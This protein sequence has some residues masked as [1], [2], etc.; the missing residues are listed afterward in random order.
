[1]KLFK[2]IFNKPELEHL[3]IYIVDDE[4]YYLNL[5]KVNI[6]KLGYND[7]KI[8][9]KGEDCLL[10]IKKEKPDCVIVD[11]LMQDGLNGDQ[12][13]LQIK[14][15]H[16]EITVIILSGQEDVS[17]ATDIIKIGADDYIVKNNL[18]FFNI[19]SILKKLSSLKENIIIHTWKEKKNQKILVLLLLLFWLVATLFIIMS[20]KNGTFF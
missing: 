9:T 16:P 6:S 8:F 11:Y 15:N 13:L 14:N 4:E 1:M 20:V 19:A 3:K 5:V 12:I 7:V 18:T 2:N 17:V 10:E